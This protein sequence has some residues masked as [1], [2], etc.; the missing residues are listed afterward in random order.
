MVIHDE[1]RILPGGI[2][3][4]SVLRILSGCLAWSRCRWV[5]RSARP[6]RGLCELVEVL[7]CSPKQGALLRLRRGGN[8]SGV[9][10]HGP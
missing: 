2:A 9:E 6:I 3:V 1:T 8:R 4:K 7:G 5:G 10:W